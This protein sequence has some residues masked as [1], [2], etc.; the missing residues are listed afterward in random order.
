MTAYASL[1]P[2]GNMSYLVNESHLQIPDQNK[3]FRVSEK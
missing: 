2:L 3:A 1:Q